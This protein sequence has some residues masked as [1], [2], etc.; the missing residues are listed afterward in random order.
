MSSHR[1]CVG[2]R[3]VAARDIKVGEELFNCYLTE[4]GLTKRQRREHMAHYLFICDCAQCEAEDSG[5]DSE[6]DSDSDS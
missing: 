4:V 5:I 3:V 2:V 6:L 1:E